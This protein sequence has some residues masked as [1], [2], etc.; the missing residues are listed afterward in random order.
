MSTIAD[1]RLNPPD[2]TAYAREL[3]EQLEADC[4][5]VSVA[6]PELA[7]Y[8]LTEFDESRCSGK[9]DVPISFESMTP[10]RGMLRG[11]CEA[12]AHLTDFCGAMFFDF[13]RPNGRK[14]RVSFRVEARE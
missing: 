14:Y 1:Q 4:E 9:F 5:E 3:R 10:M 11:L 7:P 12:L 6:L 13:K 2:E 8:T